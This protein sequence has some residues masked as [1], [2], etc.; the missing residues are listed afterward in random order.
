MRIDNTTYIIGVD[1]GYGN[2]KTANTVF[3]TGLKSSDSEPLFDGN[4]LKYQNK[5]YKIG[6]CHKDYLPDKTEDEDFYLLTLAAVASELATR[7]VTKADVLLAEGLPLS[8]T[9]RQREGYRKYLMR[10]PDVEF[11][12]NNKDYQI[13]FVDC[14]IFPQGYSA[15]T[16][17]LDN[18]MDR[19]K[20]TVVL[21]DIGNGTM[22]TLF[23]VDGKPDENRC[24]T[25]ELG[26]KQCVGEAQKILMN[27]FGI[28]ADEQIIQKILLTKE[29][30]IDDEY[31]HPIIEVAENYVATIFNKL[32]NHDF[33]QK[34]MKLFV[35]GGGGL[36]IKN[37]SDYDKNRITVL[38]DIC[39]NAKGFE[40]LA[41]GL[42]WHRKQ[43]IR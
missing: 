41:Q 8:W 9:I 3:Q 26:V 36:L 32:R 28:N 25:D 12:Y 31:L 10:N 21:A 16:P 34:M 43:A 42:L 27:S 37:F 20:G 17:M 6:E 1:T 5:W 2:I 35:I 13:H 38:D 19:F 18:D 7:N 15:L 33:D 14:F 39:I 24:Y 4:I 29:A 22:N 11:N 30:D 40:Y 23:L